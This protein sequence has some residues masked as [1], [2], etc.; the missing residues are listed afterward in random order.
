M[1]PKNLDNQGGRTA[2]KERKKNKGFTLV[3][4]MVVV[5]II[6]LL[7]ALVMPRIMGQSDQARRTAAVVQIRELE[8]TLDL[9]YL[10]NGFYPTTEQ[11]IE[12]LLEKPDT[13]PEPNNYR[14]G[15]YLKKMPVGPW[16][17]SYEYRCPGEHGDYDL[18]SYGTD[19]REGGEG[20][21]A[22][23]VNWQED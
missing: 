4:I 14:P 5:V 15:G 6:G 17:R 19:G 10:D 21:N 22:D 3:E 8:Q 1:N 12:A 9:Y 11:G 16:G 23:I 20:K 13:A 18:V 7:A 2:M